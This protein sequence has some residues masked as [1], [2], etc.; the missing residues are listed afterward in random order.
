[1]RNYKGIGSVIGAMVFLL[2]VAACSKVDD[3]V[4]VDTDN[5]NEEEEPVLTDAMRYELVKELLLDADT[6]SS[7][8]VNYTSCAGE[9]LNNAFPDVYS[10]GVDSLLAAR[11]FFYTH[12]VPE[13]E[14]ERVVAD[15]NKRVY[16]MGDHGRICYTEVN[17]PDLLATIDIE[18]AGITSVSRIELIPMSLWPNNDGNNSGPFY[19]GYIV[20]DKEEGLWWLCVKACEGGEKGVLMN[21]CEDRPMIKTD[22]RLNSERKRQ[23]AHLYMSAPRDFKAMYEA[24]DVLGAPLAMKNS[25]LKGLYGLDE[26][27]APD[28]NKEQALFCSGSYVWGSSGSIR[29]LI[30]IVYT[31]SIRIY[32]NLPSISA[33]SRAEIRPLDEFYSNSWYSTDREDFDLVL[34]KA[35]HNHLM[36]RTREFSTFEKDLEKKYELKYPLY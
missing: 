14:D 20:V 27:G 9:V 21:F 16:D 1:M 35:L 22:D 28:K 18:L 13:N 34:E 26:N 3:V 30:A 25:I 36:C 7:G 29:R 31:V 12:C 4:I 11:M 23:L 8:V 5:R 19:P 10:V 2:L 6:L 17:R 24:L 33:E 32:D 15:G